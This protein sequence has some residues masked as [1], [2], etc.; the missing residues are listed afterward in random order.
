MFWRLNPLFCLASLT[1]ASLPL[2]HSP[3]I[4]V[5]VFPSFPVSIATPLSRILSS[6]PQ[7]I[8]SKPN[9]FKYWIRLR[10]SSFVLSK[11]MAVC[12]FPFIYKP[13]AP[14]F[15]CPMHP[16]FS[17]PLLSSIHL[18]LSSFLYPS[19]VYQLLSLH[20]YISVLVI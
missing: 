14:F 12:P 15:P 9:L 4:P 1:V 2:I 18:C 10:Y 13:P 11:T 17:A 3:Y 6:L 5:F 7:S 19:L 16:T 8:L 20:H